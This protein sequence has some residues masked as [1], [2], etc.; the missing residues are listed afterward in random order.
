MPSGVK[1]Q[2]PKPVPEGKQTPPQLEFVEKAEEIA[3][4][5]QVRGHRDLALGFTAYGLLLVS[6]LVIIFFQGFKFH[7]FQVESSFLNWLGGATIAQIA[8]IA[9]AVY[10]SLFKASPK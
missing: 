5:E 3:D 4:R 2:R 10:R 9:G 6:T 8:I 7:G 1:Q